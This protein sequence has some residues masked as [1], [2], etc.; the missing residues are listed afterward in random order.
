[1]KA[2]GI[3]AIFDNE[4]ETL[5]RYTVI[6]NDGDMLGLNTAGRGFSQWCGN[7]VDNYMFHS[8][9]AAWRRHCDVDKIMKH[10]LPRIIKEFKTEGNIGKK[11]NWST[12]DEETKDHIK[13]RLS[14]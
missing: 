1:M 3:K 13:Y 7:C 11:I 4:G 9:G 10:E 8:Y 6:L 14:E 2:L 12:L 5:D